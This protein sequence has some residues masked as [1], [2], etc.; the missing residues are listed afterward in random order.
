LQNKINEKD[1]K[2]EELKRE[3]EKIFSFHENEIQKEILITEPNKINIDLNN[4]LNYTKDILAKVSKILANE[5]TKNETLEQ[6]VSKLQE[7][8]NSLKKTNNMLDNNTN[9]MQDEKDD[10]SNKNSSEKSDNSMN[11]SDIS[12]ES[13]DTYAF[14]FPDKVQKKP[15]DQDEKLEE[16]ENDQGINKMNTNFKLDFSKVYSKYQSTQNNMKG[17]YNVPAN[18]KKKQENKKKLAIIKRIIRRFRMKKAS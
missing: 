4:E 15:Q 6:E 17:K 3:L 1:V 12:C 2:I 9:N 11:I 8:L 10:D 5:K 18:Y 13:R 7:E 14:K 16:D